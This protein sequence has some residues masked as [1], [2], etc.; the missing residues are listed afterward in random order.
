MKKIMVLILSL[1]MCLLAGSTRLAFIHAEPLPDA[2]ETTVS[3]SYFRNQ[4]YYRVL[5]SWQQSASRVSL[6][7]VRI[8]LVDQI[9]VNPD[10]VFETDTDGYG[11]QVAV[12]SKGSSIEYH[13]SVS[14]TG[15]YEVGFDF[16]VVSDFYTVPLVR[17]E[18]NGAPLFN[19]ASS[20]ELG[21]AWEVVPL[22]EADRY[23]RY[24]NE[25]LP[26]SISVREWNKYYFDDYNNQTS[27]NY[28]FLLEAGSNTLRFTAINLAIKLGDLYL[29]GTEEVADYAAYR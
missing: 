14:E 5:S 1:G 19:E 15:L 3:S 17:F 23:N 26:G 13:V 28:V 18:V 7:E 27:G 10:T 2:S 16:I 12:L 20:M 6:D 25:L 21:V 4:N 8:P 24:G 9:A 29:K 11:S 22:A